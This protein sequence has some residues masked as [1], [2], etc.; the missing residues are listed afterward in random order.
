[1]SRELCPYESELL[2]ALGRGFLG[3]ELEA[4]INSCEPCR[5]LHLVAS[6]LL[7]DRAQAISEAPVPTSGRMWWRM[8]LRQRHDA[9]A[10]ARQSLLAGQAVTLTVAISLVIV[11]FGADALLAV[12]GVIETFRL[13][14]PLLLALATSLILAPIAGWVAIRQKN[15]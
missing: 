5:E 10:R 7:D 2:D 6:V 15:E 9:E 11:F 1:M 12:Q 3:G 4:H 14:T 8:R 13:S